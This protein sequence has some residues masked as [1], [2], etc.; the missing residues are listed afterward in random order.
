MT[1]NQEAKTIYG[2]P[3][4]KAVTY[5]QVRDATDRRDLPRT[6]EMAKRALDPKT[7]EREPYEYR[8]VRPNREV[9]WIYARGEASFETVDGI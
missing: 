3:L 4:D 2:F 6:S 5:A 7:R 1:D 8:I 9:R